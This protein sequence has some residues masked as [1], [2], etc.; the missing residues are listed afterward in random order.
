[1]AHPPCQK[2]RGVSETLD[3]KIRVQKSVI[4][5]ERAQPLSADLTYSVA[6]AS[7]VAEKFAAV[8]DV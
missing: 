7:V 5:A 6:K 3:S 1:M 2:K 4:D 8:Q